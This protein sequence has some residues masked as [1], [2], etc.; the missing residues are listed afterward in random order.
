MADK[1]SAV[2]P[3]EGE[4]TVMIADIGN[5]AAASVGLSPI[6]LVTI[7]RRH[8]D[9]VIDHIERNG[10]CI[11][12]FIGDAVA[13]YWRSSDAPPN[14]AQQSFDASCR[15]IDALPAFLQSQGGLSYSLDIVLGT[16]EMA[17]AFFG[18]ENRFQV[19]GKAKAVAKRISTQFRHGGSS[20][21]MSQYTRNLLADTSGI[22]Q[23]GSIPRDGLEDL[24][25]FSYSP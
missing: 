19:I 13:A 15:M 21:R 20:I 6:D 12:M 16:G 18:P 17:G 5:L 22:E 25:V 14:H 3:F 24:L 7:M 9:F 8:L 2:T 11:E 1:D 23:T 4:G 10:G